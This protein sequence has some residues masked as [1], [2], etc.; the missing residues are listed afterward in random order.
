MQRRILHAAVVDGDVGRVFMLAVVHA[1]I[2]LCEGL[3]KL[4]MNVYRGWIGEKAVRVLRLAASALVDAMPQRDNAGIQGTAGHSLA[5]PTRR[6][7]VARC[8]NARVR[9]RASHGRTLDPSSEFRT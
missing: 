8:S 5:I 9:S 7:F 3:V 4:L 1:G 6:E 2:V